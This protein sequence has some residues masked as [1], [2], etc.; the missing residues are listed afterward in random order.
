MA[1]TLDELQQS[2]KN[3]EVFL[4]NGRNN[5][6]ILE[7]DYNIRS[8][9]RAKERADARKEA[10]K[11]KSK[12]AANIKEHQSTAFYGFSEDEWTGF[13]ETYR[14]GVRDWAREQSANQS[15]SEVVTLAWTR[16]ISD[17]NSSLLDKLLG[18]QF[19]YKSFFQSVQ[20]A[21]NI[22]HFQAAETEINA[23]TGARGFIH[24]TKAESL[25][26]M[27]SR[28]VK[29]AANSYSGCDIT[30]SITVGGK[31]FVIGNL[32]A[33]SYSVH[34]DKVPVRTLGRTYAKSYV[35]GGATIAGTLVFTVF[36]TH[37]LDAVRREVV[38]EVQAVRGQSSP[39]T[40]Q[41]PPFD[42]T[43]FFQNEYGHSSYMRIY[44][45]EITDEAQTHNINDIYTEN[46]MQ[47]VARDID[48]MCKVDD[49]MF[50]PQALA[51]GNTT[52][53]TQF[54]LATPAYRLQH[55][56]D[57]DKQIS[58]LQQDAA[59]IGNE[60]RVLTT[61]I[62]ELA[63]PPESPE[64]I[65]TANAYKVQLTALQ[66]QL[67]GKSDAIINL[68]ADNEKLTSS[69]SEVDDASVNLGSNFSAGRDDPYALS[70]GRPL[71]VR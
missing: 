63:K 68:Q 39:L 59:R 22:E 24:P 16:Y 46:V 45:L 2:L 10:E 50:T 37:V 35:S 57:N 38:T 65:N 48:L 23:V 62:S 7:A 61:K 13:S 15:N 30:P 3:T 64:K 70:R 41:L 14:R 5:D 8:Q 9:E 29:R 31:T 20:D 17:G 55:K 28:F 51:G 32:S 60:I 40:Q 58:V 53:F 66:N 21:R 6:E 69:Q 67:A 27:E 34:R 71:S 54:N 43:I 44:G 36:D 1:N 56:N 26:D 11:D 52:M 33:I 25:R 18:P 4:R 12:L 19:K 49:V 42:V 47:Y